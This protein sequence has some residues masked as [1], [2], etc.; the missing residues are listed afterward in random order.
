MWL[1]LLLTF[2][3]FLFAIV[4]SGNHSVVDTKSWVIFNRSVMRNK[5]GVNGKLDSTFTITYTYIKGN[6]FDSVKSIT[7]RKYD[8]YNNLI[9]EKE[10]DLIEDGVLKLEYEKAS[11]YDSKNRQTH[12]IENFVGYEK[13]EYWYRYN[14]AGYLVQILNAQQLTRGGPE[15]ISKNASAV[16]SVSSF[17]RDSLGNIKMIILTEAN[18]DTTQIAH[19]VYFNGQKLSSYT[20]G[21]N[22]DTISTVSYIK[23][24]NYTKEITNHFT[25]GKADTTWRLGDKIMQSIMNGEHHLPKTKWV[26][27][28]DT[29]GN[30]LESISYTQ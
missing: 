28:Y 16:T 3:L 19:N 13:N 30:R 20:I 17:I 7:V 1:L 2:T 10:L 26:S 11:R 9:S 27:K 14:D 5:Y 24:G 4:G 21:K 8:N 25:S 12:L 29:F 18:L 22:G 15:P 6:L 23:E